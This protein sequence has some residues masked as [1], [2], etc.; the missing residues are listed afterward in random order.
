MR[1]EKEYAVRVYINK[2]R[3]E[4]VSLKYRGRPFRVTNLK[5]NERKY[6]T[7]AVKS[8]NA[9]YGSS[10]END[11]INGVLDDIDMDWSLVEGI[12]YGV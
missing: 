3:T 6:F 2:E 12:D 8:G 1:R 9:Y 7:I 4:D 5:P 11:M 10:W